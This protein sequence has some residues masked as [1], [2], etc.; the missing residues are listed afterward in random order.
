MT[1][2]E[3]GCLARC[4]PRCGR[5]S[6]KEFV[7]GRLRGGHTNRIAMHFQEGACFG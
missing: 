1:P 7:Q 4:R 5:L 6:L 3:Q 2:Q